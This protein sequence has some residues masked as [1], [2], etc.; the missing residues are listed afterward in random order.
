MRCLPARWGAYGGRR[1]KTLSNVGQSPMMFRGSR[2]PAPA[3]SLCCSGSEAVEIA[4][5][6]ELPPAFYHAPTP[7]TEAEL[8]PILQT[9]DQK[10]PEETDRTPDTGGRDLL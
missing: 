3:L 8:L 1:S 2:M 5:I 4:A 9:R 10:S 6:A 7:A